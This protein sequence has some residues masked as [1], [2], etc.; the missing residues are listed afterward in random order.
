MQ[1]FSNGIFRTVAQILTDS[2]ATRYVLLQWR[3]VGLKSEGDQGV[4][5]KWGSALPLPKRGGPDPRL[6]LKLRLSTPGFVVDVMFSHNGANAHCTVGLC[7]RMFRPIRQMAA[8][9]RCCR[10]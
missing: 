2:N 7:M 8:P 3:K 5:M 6:S 4:L 10:L 1:A 9:G